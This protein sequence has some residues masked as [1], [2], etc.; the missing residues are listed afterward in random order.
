M[1]CGVVP[2]LYYVSDC[3]VSSIGYVASTAT[4]ETKQN[5]QTKTAGTGTGVQDG[6]TLPA[7]IW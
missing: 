7:F 4:A 6:P 3:A 2:P 1:S 5:K